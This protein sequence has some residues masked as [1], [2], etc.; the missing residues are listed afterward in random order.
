M[1]TTQVTSTGIAVALAVVVALGLLF[2]GPRIFTPFSPTTS[3]TG[4]TTPELASNTAAV[5][6]QSS[7][8]PN[9]PS[10]PIPSPLPTELAGT[11]SKI[12]TG[13]EA[14]AGTQVTVHYVGRLADG[15]V[16][17]S[18][19]PRGEPFTFGLGA[20]QVI[21]GWDI[22]VAGMK[23][24][25]VRRLIIPASLAYGNQEVGGVIPANATLIFDIELLDVK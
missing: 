18:S 25:G 2:F 19:I 10:E 4:T 20:G 7:M 6:T 24:G 9:V 15:T 11:D 21:K 16:F 14:V 22:G 3:L 12:G 8:N 17:D 1:N 23:V 13:A 5:S